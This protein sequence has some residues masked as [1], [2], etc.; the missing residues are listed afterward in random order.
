[1][2]DGPSFKMMLV[3]KKHIF[4][5]IQSSEEGEDE[6]NEDSEFKAV[7]LLHVLIGKI[8]LGI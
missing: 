7:N 5:M 2:E 1:M 8:Y 3:L 6:I 4:N